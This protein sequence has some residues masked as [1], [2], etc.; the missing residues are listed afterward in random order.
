MSVRVTYLATGRSITRG[1]YPSS[2]W[3]S[4]GGSPQP[5]VVADDSNLV[6]DGKYT[7]QDSYYSDYCNKTLEDWE[8]YF[9]GSF[10]YDLDGSDAPNCASFAVGVLEQ[11]GAAP[12]Q[13]FGQRTY[14]DDKR[15]VQCTTPGALGEDLASHGGARK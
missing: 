1:L 13:F 4:I 15:T 6:N 10:K 2:A 14:T 5:G 7:A 3:G 11:A 8:K 9:Q 12:P